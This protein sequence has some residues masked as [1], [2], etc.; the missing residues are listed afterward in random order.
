MET[1]LGD[2]NNGILTISL[3]FELLWGLF[4]KTG[5]RVDRDYFRRTRNLIPGLLEL[6]QAYG[7]EVTWATVG[8]RKSLRK[9]PSPSCT[10]PN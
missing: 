8:P 4:D 2:K 9:L 3:D 5:G 10:P 6:F 7:V 1:S